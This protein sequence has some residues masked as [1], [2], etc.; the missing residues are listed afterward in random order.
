MLHFPGGGSYHRDGMTKKQFWN[1]NLFKPHC[2]LKP[3]DLLER[4]IP[5]SNKGLP[6]KFALTNRETLLSVSLTLRYKRFVFG[7]RSD[8]CFKSFRVWTLQEDEARVWWSCWNTQQG[9][10]RKFHD[11]CFLLTACTSTGRR[12][13]SICR[14]SR[15]EHSHPHRWMIMRWSSTS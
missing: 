14:V 9:R 1:R 5:L 8:V 15:F 2:T 12:V 4:E 3:R 13:L 6:V 10:G 7:P 11:L